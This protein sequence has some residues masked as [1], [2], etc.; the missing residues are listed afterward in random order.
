MDWERK[1]GGRLTLTESTADAPCDVEVS[2]EMRR[3]GGTVQGVTYPSYANGFLTSARIE[4]KGKFAGTTN[5]LDTLAL[6]ARHEFGHALG[7]GHWNVANHLMSPYLNARTDIDDCEAAAVRATNG[8]YLGSPQPSSPR[9]P[10]GR[11]RC[12]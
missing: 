2:I 3:G 6:I 11:H 9:M 12:G 5:D 1:V 7:L 8:W 10:R 4:I